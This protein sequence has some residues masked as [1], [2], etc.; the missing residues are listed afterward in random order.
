MM[1]ELDQ[2]Y[3]NWTWTVQK[4]L[5]LFSLDRWGVLLIGEQDFSLTRFLWHFLRTILYKM[6]ATSKFS[7]FSIDDILG[8][9]FGPSP[10]PPE[11][12]IHTVGSGSGHLAGGGGCVHGLPT[13]SL[14]YLDFGFGPSSSFATYS[15]Y[16]LHHAGFSLYPN[17]VHTVHNRPAGFHMD[18][19]KKTLLASP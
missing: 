9:G 2:D 11:A 5:S 17:A 4:S 6:E 18:T 8:S 3:K 7:N 1:S 14:N 10:S 16:A 12:R 19:G 13:L 15:P